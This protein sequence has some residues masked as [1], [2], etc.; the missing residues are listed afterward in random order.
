MAATPVEITCTADTFVLIASAVTTGRIHKLSN[1]PNVYIM[2]TRKAGDP[3]PTDEIGSWLIFD[4]GNTETISD[5]AAIDVY[6][7]ARR[8]DGKISVVL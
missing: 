3:A 7:K 1:L 8:V 2:V 5:S 6:I 4:R